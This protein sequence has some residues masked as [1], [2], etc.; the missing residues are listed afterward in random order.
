MLLWG[1]TLPAASVLA[2]LAMGGV[3]GLWLLGAAL[4]LGAVWAIG[5]ILLRRRE[6]GRDA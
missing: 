6:R 2:L 5:E 3:G 4:A 1:A